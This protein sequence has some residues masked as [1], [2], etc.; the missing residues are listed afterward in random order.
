MT[1]DMPWDMTSD[2]TFEMKLDMTSDLTLDMISDILLVPNVVLSSSFAVSHENVDICFR[3]IR[4]KAKN[5][6][7][8]SLKMMMV[9]V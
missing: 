7:K 6:F 3:P 2:M 9:W 1:S 4:A 5:S 8:G